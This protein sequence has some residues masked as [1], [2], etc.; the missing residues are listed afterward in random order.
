MRNLLAL[1]LAS[2]AATSMQHTVPPARGRA[3][4]AK[5]W[6]VVDEK[7]D[8]ARF[9][10]VPMNLTP[11]SL[12]RLRY[13]Y[14]I[15]HYSAEGDTYT[16]YTIRAEGGVEVEVQFDKGR[17]SSARTSSPNAVGP[18]GVGVGSPL[19]AVKAAWPKGRVSYG[20]QENQAYVTFEAAEPGFMP[21]V[22]F[23]FDPK[24]MPAHAF[25]R[26]HR[27]ARADIEAPQNIRVKAIGIFPRELP[28]ETYD[29]LA[30]TTGPCVPKIG[31]RTDPRQLLACKRM[32]PK[33]RYRGTWLVGFETSLF[34]PAEKSSCADAKALANCAELVGNLYFRPHSRRACPKLYRLEFIGHRNALPGTD[35]AYRITVDEVLAYQPLPD[36]PHQPG[37]CDETAV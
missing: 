9:Y 25:D 36:P 22:Y 29:F 14:K 26:D 6:V 15:G 23:Y 27:Q 10:G 32:T 18:N 24:D 5:D 1:L 21:N 7:G 19:S 20:V 11:A 17:L 33:R 13:R 12:K 4:P 2:A 3:T 34:A 8:V 28:E 16:L 30:V 37:E 35:P 31:V